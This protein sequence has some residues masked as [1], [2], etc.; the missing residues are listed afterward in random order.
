MTNIFDAIKNNNLEQ[1]KKAIDDGADINV[2]RD[3]GATPLY[4]AAGNGHLE[5][6]KHLLEKEGIEVNKANKYGLTPSIFCCI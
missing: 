6:V 3:G 4:F 1:L 5:V 2:A